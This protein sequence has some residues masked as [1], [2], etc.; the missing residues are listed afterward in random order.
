MATEAGREG[1]EVPAAA[2]SEGFEVSAAAGC[3]D[4][5]ADDILRGGADGSQAWFAGGSSTG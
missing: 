1:F 3:K 5:G 4:W 2:G